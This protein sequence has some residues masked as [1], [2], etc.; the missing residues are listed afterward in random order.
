MKESSQ[1]SIHYK[2]PKNYSM[3][4]DTDNQ[5]L[6]EYKDSMLNIASGYEKKIDENDIKHT[7]KH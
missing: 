2:Q 4:S 6:A 5:V 1:R 7:I 3:N